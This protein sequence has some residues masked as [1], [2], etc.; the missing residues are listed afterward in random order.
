MNW[1]DIIILITLGVSLFSG[2]SH[3]FIKELASFAAL[4]L[5]IWGAIKFS[6]FTAVKLYE[7]F[8]MTGEL[9]GL[10]SFIITFLAIVVIVNFIGTAI[11]KVVDAVSL[12]FLN[13]ILGAVFSVFKSVLI[14]SVVIFILNTIDSHRKFLP[15]EKIASSRLYAPVG[16]V[17]PSLF[18]IIREGLLKDTFDNRNNRGTVRI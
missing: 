10:A 18:P 8:D 14:L 16:D 4:I 1:I 12:G 7:W 9:V 3:G 15:E 17:A 13:K 2:F 6:S 11:D 5:G